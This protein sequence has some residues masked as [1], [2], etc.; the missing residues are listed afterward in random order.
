MVVAG[1]EVAGTNV[2][3]KD[4]VGTNIVEMCVAGTGAAMRVVAVPGMSGLNGDKMAAPVLE[5]AY[6]GLPTGVAVTVLGHWER[7]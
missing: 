3:G 7:R 5:K 2:D 1:T 6:S 4:V